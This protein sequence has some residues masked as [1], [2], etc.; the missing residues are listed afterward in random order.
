MITAPVLILLN[1]CKD[2]QV[3][4]DAS[5]QGLGGVIMQEGRVVLYTL[6]QLQPH[7]LNYAM[8]DLELAV[9]VHALKT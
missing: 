6:S 8:H 9:V 3:Y 4:C 7:E 5:C 1:I 2:F